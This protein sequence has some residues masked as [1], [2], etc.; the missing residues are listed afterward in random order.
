MATPKEGV[1]NRH[2][3]T[4]RRKSEWLPIGGA[5]LA[6]AGV[7]PRR[8]RRTESVDRLCNPPDLSRAVHRSGEQSVPLNSVHGPWERS[9]AFLPN[10][11]LAACPASLTSNAPS[12][13]ST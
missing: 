4:F 1:V 3:S 5:L 13:A 11:K 7:A 9:S 10:V 6:G 2:P 12:A 8:E